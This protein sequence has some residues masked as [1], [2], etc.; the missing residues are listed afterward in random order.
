MLFPKHLNAVSQPFLYALGVA[1]AYPTSFHENTGISYNEELLMKI[2]PCNFGRLKII[3]L[4]KTNRIKERF[5]EYKISI[6]F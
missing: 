2:Q 5:I 6:G 3:E 1:R 4:I